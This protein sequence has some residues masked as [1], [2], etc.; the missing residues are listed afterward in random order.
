MW[1]PKTVV[2]PAGDANRERWRS[3]VAKAQEWYPELTA[4]K[5]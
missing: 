5:F 3:A 2:E 4:L 1:R